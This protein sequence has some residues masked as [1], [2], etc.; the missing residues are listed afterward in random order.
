[1]SSFG[2]L[3]RLSVAGSG[4]TYWICHESLRLIRS[5]SSARI[6]ITTFTNENVNTITK[7]LKKQNEGISPDRITVISWY[8]FLLRDWIR[9]YQTVFPGV[10]INAIRSLNYNRNPFSRS[11]AKTDMERY[12][13]SSGDVWKDNASDLAFEIETKSGG[14]SSER[15]GR[16]VSHVFID[17]IQDFKG[18]DINLVESLLARDIGFACVGDEK[19]ATLQTHYT[20]KNKKTTGANIRTWAK[21]QESMGRLRIQ[22][23]AMSRRFNNGICSFANAV[24]PGGMTM[25]TCMK[26]YS[27][28]D[29]VF[30]ISRDS[31]AP[32]VGKFKPN[33][34]RYDRTID[35]MNLP[36]MNFGESKGDT[37]ERV[38]VFI[39]GPIEKFL[40][41][42]TPFTSPAKYY[43][44]VTR[45]RYSL[46]FV[47]DDLTM[48]R[49]DFVETEIDVGSGTSIIGLKYSPEGSAK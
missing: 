19:Q 7:E 18:Y 37:Y 49:S 13:D 32:Y 45:P 9:P 26:E 2:K 4:K 33:V 40:T 43:V 34:L 29:G 23:E 31:V 39:N 11:Y 14:E 44:G 30:C 28:H 47:V 1:M 38:L 25:T 8:R 10:G 27:G 42:K 3:V 46:A 20:N 48:V 17:E 36:A 6:L 12:V 15:I 41:K 21:Q 16:M 35:T 22:E 24:S 5:D